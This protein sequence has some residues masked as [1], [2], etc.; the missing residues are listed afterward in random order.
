MVE[1]LTIMSWEIFSSSLSDLNTLSTQLVFD[2]LVFTRC[3]DVEK[4][5]RQKKIGVK[6]LYI[7]E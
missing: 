7:K 6:Y 1:S 4:N 2:R 5:M 3:A